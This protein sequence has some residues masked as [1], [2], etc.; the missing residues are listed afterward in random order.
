METPLKIFIGWDSRE[1]I[2]Y[3]VAKASIE[4]HASV[5]V[6]IVPIRLKDLKKQNMYWRPTDKL[7]STEFTFS[8][9][10]VPAL[11]NYTGWALFI[12]CDFLF[13]DDVKSLFDQI[14]DQ[15]AIMCAKH[16][17]TPKPGVK[18]DGKLQTQYPRKNWSSMMLINCEHPKNKKYLTVEQ[19]N[20]RSITPAYVHR[21]SW[22]D[23]EDIGTLSHEWNWLVGWYK[24]PADGKPKA[25]HYTE[26]GPWFDDYKTCEYAT[27]WNLTLASHAQ[28]MLEEKDKKIKYLRDRDI[29][30]DD[31]DYTENL[32]VK[33]HNFVNKLVDPTEQ[34]IQQKTIEDN[35][36]GSVKVAAIDSGFN[37]AKKELEFDPILKSLA[38]GINGTVSTFEREQDT[39]SLLV[40]RGAGKTSR[41]ALQFCWNTNRDFYA[42]DTGYFGNKKF[43][44]YHRITKNKLQYIGPVQDR[45][46]DRF[47][48]TG[49]K[50]RNFTPGT[51]ILVCPPSDKIMMLFGLADPKEWTDQ[52][53][54]EIQKFTDRPIEIRLKPTTRLER[55]STNTIWDALED[56]VHCLVTFNSIAATEALLHGVHAIALGENAASSLCSSSL[57]QIDNLVF[58]NKDEIDAFAHHLAY[59]QF[60][61]KEMRNGTAWRILNENS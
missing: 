15:Y 10:L 33:I 25:L 19:I 38:L 27:E 54:K 32:K 18:M 29:T 35:I 17:Y 41:E 31:L 46:A 51:K 23:D 1:D 52:I 20:S 42:I 7:A 50:I 13:L 22:L 36:M 8:R 48:A 11:T 56:D 6:E 47:R 4:E 3:Q 28:R 24:E 37:Y 30:I 55:I 44:Y 34:F 57:S 53:V 9:Y 58:P 26:G 60:T 21:F 45:P 14:D 61:E 59:Q 49:Q 43:K 5:P 2:A 40:I 39:D 12:D 16:D